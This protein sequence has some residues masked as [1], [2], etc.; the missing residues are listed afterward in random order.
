MLTD[1][2]LLIDQHCH[3]VRDADLGRHDCE[4]LMTEADRVVAGRSPFDSMLGVA[5]RR[6]CAPVLG[7]A[8][9]TSAAEYLARRV[10]LGWRE[11]TRRLLRASGTRMWLLDT[12]LTTQPLT[13]VAEFAELGDGQALEVVRLEAVAEEVAGSGVS[14]AELATAVEAAVRT[15]ARKAVGLKTVVAYRCGLRVPSV[16][17]ADAAVTSAASAWLA[18][19]EA[20]LRDPVLLAWLVHRGAAIGAEMGLP[21]QV[22]TGFGDADLQLRDADPVLLTDF[23]KSTMDTGVTLILLHCWPFHRNAAYL[24][25]VFPH[26]MVDLGLTIPHVGTRAAAVLAETLELAPWRAVCFSSDGYGL[27]ELHH[28]GAALWRE[29]FGR[30]LDE[31]ISDDVL[32]VEDA[33]R[34]AADIAGGNAARVYELSLSEN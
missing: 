4:L 24:A 15:R 3:G 29:R 6:I 22:H 26:V 32:R 2:L 27:P 19:G 23:L 28:L 16:A 18:S 1:D 30:L 25:H 33:Q 8:P 10:D 14:A 21:L 34:L 7:L 13:G 20:R 11:V 31:W 12:G 5:L 9:H 17:P